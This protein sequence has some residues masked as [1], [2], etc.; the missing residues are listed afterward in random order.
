MAML[1]CPWGRKTVETHIKTQVFL[2]VIE[3]FASRKSVLAGN[4]LSSAGFSPTSPFLVQWQW[5]GEEKR[6]QS[7]RTLG[8]GHAPSSKPSLMF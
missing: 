8:A 5:E 1:I 3:T 7:P 2:M 6:L 4:G